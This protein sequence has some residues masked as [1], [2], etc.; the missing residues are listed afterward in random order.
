MR[1][2]LGIVSGVRRGA[3]R[4]ANSVEGCER[5]YSD[6]RAK[7]SRAVSVA[8]WSFIGYASTN[9]LDRRQGRRSMYSQ[10]QSYWQLVVS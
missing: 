3:T 5:K 2:V 1:E 6:T 4:D 9:R 8:L 10:A 7:V